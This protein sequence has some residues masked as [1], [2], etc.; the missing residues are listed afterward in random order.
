MAR[1]SGSYRSFHHRCH[2][3]T[4]RRRDCQIR[5]SK[6]VVGHIGTAYCLKASGHCRLATRTCC[7]TR[8]CHRTWTYPCHHRKD[9][10]TSN[11][12]CPCIGTC[13]ILTPTLHR[14]RRGSCR[15]TQSSGPH[16]RMSRSLDY[17]KLFPQRSNRPPL[18]YRRASRTRGSRRPCGLARHILRCN[19]RL[20]AILRL[21]GSMN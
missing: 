3:L 16:H 9:C 11:D 7:R 21:V 15:R 8:N 10:H 12:S 19:D 5:Y 13:P 4:R 2:C 20:G 14:H 1:T 17:R 6:A 18:S